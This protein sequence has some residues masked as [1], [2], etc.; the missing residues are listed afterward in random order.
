M[1]TRAPFL[2][3]PFGGYYHRDISEQEVELTIL[4][5]ARRAGNTC[6][7]SASR[8]LVIFGAPAKKPG[9]ATSRNLYWARGP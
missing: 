2:K 8:W 4:A 1:V 6:A 3:T 7:A 9:P 5:R